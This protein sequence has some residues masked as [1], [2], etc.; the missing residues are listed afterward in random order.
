MVLPPKIPTLKVLATGNLIRVDNVFCDENLVGMFLQCDT[1]P[2]HRPVKTD[3]FPI[4]SKIRLATEHNIFAPRYNFRKADWQKF[5]EKLTESLSLLP[6][7]TEITDRQQASDRLAALD[8]EIWRAVE[9]YVP[10]T[11]LCPHSKRW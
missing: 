1:K 3:H 10:E 6:A 11:T 8:K 2:T 7:P 4:I 9:E 5:A